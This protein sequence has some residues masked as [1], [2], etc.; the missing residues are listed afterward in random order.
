MFSANGDIFFTDQ[1]QT[2]VLHDPSGC[3]YRYSADGILSRLI[4]TAPSP[5][6]L[7]LDATGTVLHLAVTRANQDLA[8]AAPPKRRDD[9]GEHLRLPSW[10]AR[11]ADGL[12]LDQEGL[13]AGRPSR[14]LVRY[15]RSPRA[16]PL[17]QI[18]SCAGFSTTNL[19]FGG[20]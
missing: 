19:A 20:P 11:V 14:V 10:R 4:D 2:G 15:G 7:V 12:A 1:G 13:S 9:Q 17:D 3:V 8:I 6:G 5:N 18:V 16:E